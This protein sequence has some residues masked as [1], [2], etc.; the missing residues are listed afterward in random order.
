[1]TGLDL[2]R[3]PERA[4]DDAALAPLASM[5]RRRIA[6]EP[7]SRILAKR[8]F[9]GLPLAISPDVLDPRPD[10]ETLVEAVMREFGGR[11]GEPLRILDLGV[12]SGAILCAL[13]KEFGEARGIGVDLSARAAAQARENLAACGLAGRGAI[14]VGRWGEALGRPFDIVVS[15]PP[16]IASGE[17]GGLDREVRDHDPVMALDGGCDGLDAY[18]AIAR[19]VGALLDEG[20]RF[21][22]ELGAGQSQAVKEIFARNGLM[23]WATY[24]D[25]TGCTRVLSGG[26]CRAEEVGGFKNKP[27]GAEQKKD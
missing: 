20:G 5:A 22:L 9:W 3:D 11:R 14:V 19:Q 27:L 17:V 2:I 24:S 6:G 13:L 26:G 4:L 12:G 10:T 25:L 7:V 1:L 16:Y 8:E 21:F 15:N 23:G 18:R